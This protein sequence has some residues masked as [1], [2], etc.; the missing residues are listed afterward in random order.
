MTAPSMNSH[1]TRPLSLRRAAQEIEAVFGFVTAGEFE[2]L[3]DRAADFLSEPELR[4]FAGLRFER[5]QQSYLLG[6]FAAK[7]AAGEYL[8]EG[9]LK[10]IEVFAGVFE[11]PLVKY[12][13]E[14][15]PGVSISHC[16][17]L[18]VALAFP[19]GHPMG[20]DVEG[21]S[22][23]RVATMK[24]QMTARELGWAESGEAREDILC[25]VVWTAKEA[26]SKV[27]K[28]GLMSPM[29]IM[30]LSDLKR[31]AGGAWEGLFENFAQYKS[32]SWT[33]C[34]HVGSVLSIV[35]PK[36]SQLSAGP[37]LASILAR[38]G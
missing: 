17:G 18:A 38:G 1:G 11:Q 26:L 36:N 23:E 32:A 37:D 8:R 13:A 27:L 20:I 33:A 24:S 15:V 21:I 25:A 2:F 14:D 7:L 31:G 4:Y 16:A 12:L 22:A 10:K 34:A 5:R 6:R 9:A 35:L 19:A 3:R 30:R 29:E 28:C